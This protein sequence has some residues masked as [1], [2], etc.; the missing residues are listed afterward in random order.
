MTEPARRYRA[1]AQALRGIRSRNGRTAATTKA[2]ARHE[3]IKAAAVADLLGRGET[4]LVGLLVQEEKL[5]ERLRGGVERPE[6]AGLLME[7][8]RKLNRW[9]DL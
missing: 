6:L 1:A 5:A 9:Q 8:R 7:I 3:A 4:G 2:I